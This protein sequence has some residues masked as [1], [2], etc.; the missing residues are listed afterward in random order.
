MQPPLQ[1][2]LPPAP[3]P[4]DAPGSPCPTRLAF[5]QS[6]GGLTPVCSFSGHRAVLS[7]PAAGV[8][9]YARTTW[10]ACGRRPVVALDVGG[11][12]SDVSRFAGVYEHVY[13]ATIAGI[14][15]SA[16]Q[17]DIST[18]AAGGGSR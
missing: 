5:M 11:T 10:E 2:A 17:L 9:G 14:A 16:P 12:S 3:P 6:D 7:G 18:V 1:S 4:Q 13:E 8:V 15:I